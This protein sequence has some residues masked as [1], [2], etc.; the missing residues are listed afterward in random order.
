MINIMPGN[1]R[2]ISWEYVR[3][4]VD[5]EGCFTFC[6]T[7]KRIDGTSTKVRLPTF[8]LAMSAQDEE[9]MGL[10][11]DRLGLKNKIYSYSPRNN[12][13]SQNRQGMCILI[14]R[15]FPQLK[16]VIVPLF[17]NKLHGNKGRQL[18]SWL[19]QM[20][21]DSSVPAKYKLLE[22]WSRPGGFYEK[23]DIFP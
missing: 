1:V 6:N 11:R 19:K 23:N 14:V 18:K 16:N 20:K 5:G 8:T 21:E 17:L 7:P 9:L 3:G 4:L 15:D 12:R 13:F 22:I 10:I 2:K